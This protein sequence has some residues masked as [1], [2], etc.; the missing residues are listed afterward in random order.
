MKRAKTSPGGAKELSPARKRWVEWE[1]RPESRRD[2]RGCDTVSLG[3]W[4]AKI[5]NPAPPATLPIL[6][7]P[8]NSS[9]NSSM[10][11]ASSEAKHAQLVERA[12]EWL[13]YT[14]RCG[15]VL[16]EQYCA[17]GEVPDVIGWK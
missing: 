7:K 8:R 2:G 12:V 17:S 16:S 1:L 10:M 13:R 11:R 3:G 15:I 5:A 4:L 9:Y 6:P 14:Y